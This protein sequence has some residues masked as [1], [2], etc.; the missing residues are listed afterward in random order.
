MTHPHERAT[1]DSLRISSAEF[2]ERR[3]RARSLAKA[4]GLA[5]LVVWSRNATT[6]DWYGDVMYFTNRPRP[7]PAA[8]RRPAGLVGPRAQRARVAGERGSDADRRHG[9]AP[10]RDLVEIDDVRVGFNVPRC[11]REGARRE[12]P[13][14]RA[15]RAASAMR[16]CSGA[17]TSCCAEALGRKPRSSPPTRSCSAL[18][19]TQERGGAAPRTQCR[20]RGLRVRATAMMEAIG[21]G[22]RKATSSARAC[23]C[24]RPRAASSRTTSQSRPGLTP[25][26]L[27]VGRGCRRGTASVPC[28]PGMS[29]ASTAGARR[30]G[31]TPISSAR[32]RSAATLRPPRPSCSRAPSRSS[33]T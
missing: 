7:V 12:G 10:Q 16:A 28:R 15:A 19:R 20:A 23:A 1:S 33:S 4:Q 26:Q 30:S 3:E 14:C 27:P 6:A 2:E 29:F 9:R 13:R 21:P 17:A 24:R 22:R 8:C 32:C 18:R 31:C 11:V 25:A 5:G